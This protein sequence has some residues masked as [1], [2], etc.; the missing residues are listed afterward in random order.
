MIKLLS[1]LNKTISFVGYEAAYWVHDLIAKLI[2]SIIPNEK[3]QDK[4]D[5]YNK[6]FKSSNYIKN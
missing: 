6:N 5:G 2:E 1:A 3:K 4:G